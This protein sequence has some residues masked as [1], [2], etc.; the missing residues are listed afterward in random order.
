MMHAVAL[1]ALSGHSNLYRRSPLWPEPPCRLLGLPTTT[2]VGA[3]DDFQQV[4]ARVFEIY[5]PAAVVVVDFPGSRTPWV[6]PVGKAA[7]SNARMNLVKF[8]FA[9]HERVVLRSD[10]LVAVHEINV[11][12][13]GRYDDLE[14]APFLGRWQVQDVSKK[15]GRSLAVS[16]PNDG[17][18]EFDAH[19]HL[20]TLYDGDS[21]SALVERAAESGDSDSH[22]NQHQYK[23]CDRIVVQIGKV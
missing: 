14:G 9:H 3:S 23:H 2:P 5:A 11:D 21:I 12:A 22:R 13:I 17:M 18:V 16:G 20:L 4:P 15:R 10:L 7:G 6:G 8:R 19:L 1:P